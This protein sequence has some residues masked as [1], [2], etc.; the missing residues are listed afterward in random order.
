MNNY[1]VHYGMPR[2]SGRYPYGSGKNPYQHVNGALTSLGRDKYKELFQ[3]NTSEYW[4]SLISKKEGDRSTRL[5]S[6]QKHD[7][8]D[9]I[10]KGSRLYR[11]ASGDKIDSRPKYVS[12]ST[13][14]R[15]IYYEGAKLGKLPV[16]DIRRVCTYKYKA[17]KD[18]KIAKAEE[19]ASYILNKYGTKQMLD[20]YTIDSSLAD[21][22]RM[23]TAQAKTIENDDDREFATFVATRMT[24]LSITATQHEYADAFIKLYEDKSINSDVVTEFIKRGYDA[25]QDVQ[26][27]PFS[28]YSDSTVDYPMILLNPKDSIK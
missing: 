21:L 18:I 11:V 12:P 2:R 17:K 14:D 26:D 8:F 22:P 27:K 7:T 19:V 13:G 25:I 4:K 15:D 1:L 9:I 3:Q 10:P 23:Y 6:V 20:E 16:G 5:S 28:E 24:D